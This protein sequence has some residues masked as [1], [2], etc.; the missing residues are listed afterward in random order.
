M[1]KI[2]IKCSICHA[3]I[4]VFT[5]GKF[6]A[7]Y[8]PDYPNDNKHLVCITCFNR[9]QLNNEIKKINKKNV[10]STDTNSITFKKGNY[11][12]GC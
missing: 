12:E 8:H 6:A 11:K 3:L 1:S 2:I 9:I 7:Y 10:I 4:N 5:I